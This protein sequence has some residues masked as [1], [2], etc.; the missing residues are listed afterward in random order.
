VSDERPFVMREVGGT[1]E[2]CALL[3][4]P[5][6]LCQFHASIADVIDQVVT[7]TAGKVALRGAVVELRG[8]L[9]ELLE[10]WDTVRCN[11]GDHTHAAMAVIA[12][13]PVT[14]RVRLALEKARALL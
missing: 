2:E 14:M 4:V 11:L 3:N 13:E 1:C 8:A 9:A 5:G 12:Y 7:A 10:A 6:L